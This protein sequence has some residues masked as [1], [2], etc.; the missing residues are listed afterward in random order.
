[1]VVIIG[2][3]RSESVPVSSPPVWPAPTQGE[4]EPCADVGQLRACWEGGGPRLVAR[5]LPARAASSALGWRCLGDGA[6]RACV[7]R[8]RE[9]A[10]FACARDR[11]VQR[12]PRQPD[13]GEWSCLD[14]AGATMCLGADAAAG[15]LPG[16]TAGWMCGARR[17]GQRVCVDLSPDFPDG[18]AAGWRC[19]YERAPAS[20]RVCERADVHVLG[21]RC[22]AGQPCVDGSRCVGGR[23]LPPR[24]R[25]SCFEDADCPGSACRFG[26]CRDPSP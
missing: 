24:P 21:D 11:C 6:R 2:C 16:P 12:H 23:C 4:G 5:P 26:T 9:A 1:V 15:V 8:L 14:M 22:A 17:D 3:A 19:R 13:D 10:A 20:A 18:A 25:P 7:D